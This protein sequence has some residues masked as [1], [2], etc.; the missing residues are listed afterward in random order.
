M[1]ER[2]FS[3]IDA[4]FWQFRCDTRVFACETMVE[5]RQRLP[6]LVKEL[7]SKNPVIV[8]DDTVFASDLF[9]E[10]IPE[11]GKNVRLVGLDS[12]VG[13]I[14]KLTNDRVMRKADL[15]IGIGGGSVM[16]AV[17]ILS[18]SV[19]H[20]LA[21]TKL[22]TMTKYPKK[23]V[24]TL[25]VPTTFGTGSEVNMYTHLLGEKSRASIRNPALTPT[26]ALLVG[27]FAAHIPE[28]LRYLGGVD[29]WV[30]AFEAMTLKRERS[31]LQDSLM[32]TALDL[33]DRHFSDFLENPNPENGL[34]IATAS[35]LGG[36]GVHNSRSGLIHTLATPLFSMIYAPHAATLLPFIEPVIRHNWEAIKHH[37]NEDLDGF[38]A[39]YEDSLFKYRFREISHFN[40]S[41]MEHQMKQMV[42]QACNDSVIFKENPRSLEEDDIRK[43][44]NESLEKLIYDRSR[45]EEH[46]ERLKRRN[47]LLDKS[48]KKPRGANIKLV[49][50]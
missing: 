23:L 18:A 29:A 46:L 43:L 40:V 11:P 5:G 25:M 42:E 14:Q 24:P 38:L 32:R 35:M 9:R 13:P 45:D 36:L 28:R 15:L 3:D 12:D 2:W 1:F 10:L 30:H 34:A 17:K 27:E 20:N 49:K 48:E 26:M 4:G 22:A 6:S 47:L 31:P 50:K 44:F 37:F 19:T 21:L 16:D 8:T 33:H 39:R 41:I 7:G